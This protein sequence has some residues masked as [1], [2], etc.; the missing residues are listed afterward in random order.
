MNGAGLSSGRVPVGLGLDLVDIER[1]ATALARHP[2]MR[3][4]LFTPAERDY[5]GSFADPAPSL[6]ARFA[7]KE[8]VMKALGVGL[9]AFAFPEVEVERYPSGEPYLKL[10]GRAS[11]LASGRGVGSWLLSLTHSQMTAGAV[12]L[13]ISG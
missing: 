5:A 2:R 4:R 6:A 9:G 11:E 12:V 3:E 13:A 8:A 7:A 10:H 1:F